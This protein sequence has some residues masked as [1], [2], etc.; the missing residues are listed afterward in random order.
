MSAVKACS[1]LAMG[2]QGL[3]A[4]NFDQNCQLFVG[5]LSTDSQ[6]IVDRL[7]AI[8]VCWP[9]VGRQTIDSF[10]TVR[11]ESCSSQLPK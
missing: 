10:P 2:P 7:L 1:R 9:T 4:N 3:S 6:P 8:H 5:R 11:E